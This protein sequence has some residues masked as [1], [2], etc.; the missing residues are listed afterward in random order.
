MK[1]FLS[2]SVIS[3]TCLAFAAPTSAMEIQYGAGSAVTTVDRFANFDSLTITNSMEL[4]AYAENALSIT[5]GNQNWGADPPAAPF[6]LNPFHIEPTPTAFYAGAW[7]NLQWVTIQTT[8]SRPIYGLEFMYG[9]TWTTGDLS[10]VPPYSPWGISDATFEFQEWRGGTMVATGSQTF[11]A[12]G[13]IVGFYDQGGYDQL[14]VR[15][16]SSLSGVPN[17]QALAMDN[18][19]V[20]LSPTTIPEPSTMLLVG[21]ALTC[22]GLFRRLIRA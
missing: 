6:V 4:D 3:L 19:Q 18:L 21:G 13:T 16:T 22:L 15:A 2:I 7:E 14:L 11:L 10:G 20:Q 12:L 1:Y 5:T 8:D 9:N 17:S